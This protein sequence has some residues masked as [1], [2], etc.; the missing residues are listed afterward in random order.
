MLKL[1]LKLKNLN[2]PNK[3]RVDID[4]KFIAISERKKAENRAQILLVKSKGEQKLVNTMKQK[5]DVLEEKLKRE[6]SHI[7]KKELKEEL[8]KCKGKLVKYEIK[9][10]Q[11]EVALKENNKQVIKAKQTLRIL[12]K[13]AKKRKIERYYKRSMCFV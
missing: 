10:K 13:K 4:P 5:V 6:T 1:K 7:V 11:T 8:T 2:V 3:K 9:A 12:K